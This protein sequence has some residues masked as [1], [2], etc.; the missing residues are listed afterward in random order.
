MVAAVGRL[1]ARLHGREVLRRRNF[2]YELKRQVIESCLYGVDIQEQAVRLCEL[3]LGLSLVVDYEIDAANPFS[4]AIREVP[5]LPNL[6]Y[7]IVRGDSLLER[8]FGHVVQLDETAKDAEAKQL[9]DSMQADSSSFL[10]RVNFAEVF[11]EKGGFDV[12]LGNPPYVNMIQM[13]KVEGLRDV[14]RSRYHTARGAFDLFVPF[15]ELAHENAREAGVVSLIVPNK[16]LSAEYAAALRQFLSEKTTLVHFLD[17]SKCRPFEAA[18][19]PV[20]ILFLR[21]PATRPAMIDVYRA[22]R[23]GSQIGIQ[24]RARCEPKLLRS[25]P[26]GIWS[27]ILENGI[28][29]LAAAMSA[30]SRL[31]D[32]CTIRQAASVDEAYKV[33]KPLL[34]E[35]GDV[36]GKRHKQFLV[37]GTIDRY[38]SLWGARDTFYLKSRFAE[39]VLRVDHAR[40]SASASVRSSRRKSFFPARRVYPK[41]FLDESGDFASGIPTVLLYDAKMPLE[42]LC[43]LINSRLYRAFYRVCWSTLAMS[44]GYMR[45]GPPQVKRL[46]LPC[47]SPGEIGSIVKLVRKLVAAYRVSEPDGQIAGPLEEQIDSA[48][49]ALFGIDSEA[50]NSAFAD[51]GAWKTCS[52][53]RIRP[54]FGIPRGP[55]AV[56]QGSKELGEQA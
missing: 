49:L 47:A 35:Q 56:G 48:V 44:G 22:T 19:Y 55:A 13:D 54:L 50:F 21:R 42:Y 52:P 25:F 20:A 46:P 7:R 16:I 11:C 30:E 5:S 14:L 6:S 1:D 3:R 17:A 9:I 31:E 28:A 36:K 51:D 38:R 34:C 40:L 39:P 8:L 12:V 2:D 32:A 23:A 18:V 24:R 33:L 37:S 41:A 53:I 10:W 45:F 26:H 43:G 15:C 29:L 4:Q 27:P